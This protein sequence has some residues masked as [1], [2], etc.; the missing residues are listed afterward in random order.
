MGISST[1]TKWAFFSEWLIFRD[2]II[3]KP[4]LIHIFNSV[5]RRMV[6]YFMQ[7]FDQQGKSHAKFQVL[8]L[9][10]YS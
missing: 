3:V 8:N 9:Y 10:K 5:Q 1:E 6:D 4:R 2:L 7:A